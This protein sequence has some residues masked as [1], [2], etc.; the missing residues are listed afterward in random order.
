ML[1]CVEI[2]GRQCPAQRPGVGHHTLQGDMGQRCQM[3][4][5]VPLFNRSSDTMP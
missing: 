5:C 3:L 1:G 2:I 4:A